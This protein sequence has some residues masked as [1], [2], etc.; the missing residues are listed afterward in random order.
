MAIIRKQPRKVQK[1]VTM[2]LRNGKTIICEKTKSR[3]EGGKMLVSAGRRVTA[4][5]GTDM[6]FCLITT[7]RYPES[8][9]DW[10]CAD[11]HEAAQALIYFV[12]RDT[13]YEAANKAL[14]ED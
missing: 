8:A 14:Q 12:G 13:A 1:R 2:A 11:A 4:V 10:G 6:P 5:K 9:R 3:L 7:G